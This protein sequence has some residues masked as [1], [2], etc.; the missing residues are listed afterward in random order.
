[1]V[2]LT[3]THNNEPAIGMAYQM[4]W[5]AGMIWAEAFVR[6]AA[7][8]FP[9][10]HRRRRIRDRCMAVGYWLG[11]ASTINPVDGEQITPSAL[12]ISMAASRHNVAGGRDAAAQAA[13]GRHGPAQGIGSFVRYLNKR[14]L[15][16]CL[17]HLPARSS[18]GRSPT[19]SGSPGCRRL[20]WCSR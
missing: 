5:V 10:V 1:M 14:L 13:R 9:R 15:T 18:P 16:I 11:L 20:H 19:T 4:A 12:G 2:L 17:W 8:V 7:T 6:G 3:V